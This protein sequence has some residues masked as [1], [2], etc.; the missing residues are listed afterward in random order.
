LI[1]KNFKIEFSNAFISE[2]KIKSNCEITILNR[3]NNE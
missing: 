1:L 2:N 3:E